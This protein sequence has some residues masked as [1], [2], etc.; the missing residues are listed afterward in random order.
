MMMMLINKQEL[1]SYL[2]TLPAVMYMM[3][4][5]LTYVS[6]ETLWAMHNREFPMDP[7]WSYAVKA[8]GSAIVGLLVSNL[9]TTYAQPLEHRWV[10]YT[11]CM[12]FQLLALLHH[13]RCYFLEEPGNGYFVDS[14]M[15]FQYVVIHSVGCTIFSYLIYE[16]KKAG[17]ASQKH[18]LH[19][20]CKTAS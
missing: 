14:A 17:I 20:I 8:K 10:S 7:V 12:V 6:P 13:G 19:T 9:L 18:K 2:P 3:F 11:S 16:S 4:A 15:H 5:Y 1:L